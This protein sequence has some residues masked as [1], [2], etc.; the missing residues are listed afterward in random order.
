MVLSQNCPCSAT[1]IWLE[2]RSRTGSERLALKQLQHPETLMVVG[3][4]IAANDESFVA[5]AVVDEML[6]TREAPTG[7]NAFEVWRTRIW[8][9]QGP[10]PRAT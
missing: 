3:Q 6:A 4:V 5:A 2:L 9:T 1:R 7:W 8:E 10:G